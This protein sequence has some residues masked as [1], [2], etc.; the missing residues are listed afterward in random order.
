MVGGPGPGPD[1]ETS[2]VLGEIELEEVSRDREGFF[3]IWRIGRGERIIWKIIFND[4]FL[5]N[6][7]III[8]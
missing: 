7:E 2:L 1:G 8:Y 4:I 5:L 3:S 6:L